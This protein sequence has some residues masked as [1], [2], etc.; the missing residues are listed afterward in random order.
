MKSLV[1]YALSLILCVAVLS[2]MP[3]HG[4]EQIYDNVVRLH[5]LAA[6]DSEEDQ[7][8]KLAVRDALLATYGAELDY[9]NEADAA[10]RIEALLP[11]IK[12]LAEETL[13]A[14]GSNAP[15][16]VT[17]TDE[18]YPERT[19]GDLHFPAGT[20]HSLRILIG[21]GEGKN[22]WCVLFPPLCVGAATEETVLPEVDE[23]PPAGFTDSQWKLVSQDGRYEIR[24]RF[25][26][27]LYG[28]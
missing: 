14:R 8:D 18:N 27:L 5:I 7:A 20:Y 15:V 2:V 23:E 21:E 3:I 6:S 12:T 1:T 25:L 22:W 24:F 16:T 19:Y 28:R 11:A 9:K 17:F 4:E 10:A 13:A 26:E